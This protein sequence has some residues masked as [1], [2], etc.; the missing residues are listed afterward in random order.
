VLSI[1]TN[2]DEVASD[3]KELDAALQRAVV[4]D[5]IGP[6]VNSIKVEAQRHHRYHRKTGRLERAIRATTDADSGQVYIDEGLASY[7]RYV[8]DGTRKW[9]SDAFITDAYERK[10]LELDRDADRAVEKAIK[11]AGL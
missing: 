8:H 4:K 1:T 2:A 3:F 10:Q 7:G 9:D 6:F 5:G 11:Q